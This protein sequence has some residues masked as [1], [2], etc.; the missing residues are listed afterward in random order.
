MNHK[1]EGSCFFFLSNETTNLA[2]G[3][4]EVMMFSLLQAGESQPL[5]NWNFCHSI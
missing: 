4:A 5:H 2:S 3:V 1:E